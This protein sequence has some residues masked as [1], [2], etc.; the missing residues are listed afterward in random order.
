MKYPL[1]EDA[2]KK[3]E[4]DFGPLLD[5]SI[6][7]IQSLLAQSDIFRS[8]RILR[9]IVFVA[10]GDLKRLESA[11]RLAQIDWR[12]LLM[13]A[14]YEYPGKGKAPRQVRDFNRPFEA[15]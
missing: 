8:P 5:E 3:L 6:D 12:D 15:E 2:R 14:E 4:K 9:A 11:I 7:K 13:E 10:K 1:P